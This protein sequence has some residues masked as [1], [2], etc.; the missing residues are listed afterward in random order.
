MNSIFHPGELV[1]VF[2]AL[3]TPVIAITTTYIAIAQ[4]RIERAKFR[5]ER[6]ERRLT[7]YND[8][9]NLLGLIQQKADISIEEL[10]TLR[11]H[12]SE[13]DF[14]FGKEIQKYLDEIHDK[15]VTLRSANS[16]YRDLTQSTPPGY[17]HKKIVDQ[18]H[19]SLS[20]LA[21]QPEVAHRLFR[22]YLFIGE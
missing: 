8:L 11:R 6:Y 5:F 4:W 3:L 17:D 21:A 13:S 22:P 15:G 7:I 19:Q 9:R 1:T 10:W 20:W 16:Q 14:L 2:S 12:R 18:M